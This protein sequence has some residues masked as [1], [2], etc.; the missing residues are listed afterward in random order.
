[1]LSSIHRFLSPLMTAKS[2]FIKS[3]IKEFSLAVIPLV[4][5]YFIQ[6]VVYTLENWYSGLFEQYILY[7]IIVLIAYE[8][9]SFFTR[10]R[11][12]VSTVTEYREDIHDR[13][14]KTFISLNNTATNTLWTWKVLSILNKW[15][16]LWALEL[17][18]VT[19]NTIL[20][21]TTFIY[22]FISVYLMNERYALIFLLLYC[23]IHIIGVYI[24]GFSLKY[25][26]E[27]YT[28][29]NKYVSRLVRIIM[30]KYEILQAWK[31]N[32]EV[33]W[34]HSVN[35]ELYNANYKMANPIHWFFAIPEGFISWSQLI[36][37]VYIWSQIL[38]WESDISTLVGIF[39][40]F[41]LLWSAITNSMI[42]FKD[43]TNSFTTIEWLW[44]F[45]DSTPKISWIQSGS[46]FKYDKWKITITWLSFKYNEE[47]PNIFDR[48]NI[49]VIWSKKT[50]FVW[51][52]W[53]GKSTLIKLITGYIEPTAWS[54]S[55]DWQDL[56]TVSK[57][58][59]YNSVGYLTQ[60][61]NIFDW[62]ILENLTYWI[63]NNYNLKDNNFI[64]KSLLSAKC[65]FVRELPQWLETYIWERWVHLSWWQRQR[66][67]IA[68]I[69]LKDPSIIVLDEPTSAL[70][71]E[72]EEYISQAMEKLF[73]W[74]TVIIIAHRLQTVKDADDIILLKKWKVLERWSHEEL[75]NLWWEYWKMVEL[76]SGF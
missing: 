21:F 37:I 44:D 45:L 42:F 68:K 70:D 31:V 66:L 50:A 17:Q 39:G 27:R 7:Y 67:A 5:I 19:K 13:S 69:F 6:K 34:L 58:S 52:S 71:S 12:W 35:R 26:R 38:R 61:P 32:Q 53:W 20:I 36:I 23:I 18:G 41:T 57:K 2:T 62:T 72:S 43:F 60:E 56:A 10:R 51:P 9:F 64:K 11:W 14:I 8:F 46:K 24:N 76:Q 25:R 15:M 73:E 48:F 47:S 33:S 65:E 28:S 22:A 74:R 4:H 59:Y 49:D 54:I 29:R 3:I 1:M 40:V 16:D 63:D 75:M 30:S 55:I